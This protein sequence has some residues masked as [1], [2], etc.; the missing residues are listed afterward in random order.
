M[1]IYMNVKAFYHSNREM[2]ERKN[3]CS[4]GKVHF[5]VVSQVVSTLHVALSFGLY[6]KE[7]QFFYV[8][9]SM[10]TETK[11]HIIR[12]TFSIVPSNRF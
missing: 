6:A 10:I 3:S 8:V 5:I 2:E 11:C 12:G 9:L 7:N 4:L 1:R